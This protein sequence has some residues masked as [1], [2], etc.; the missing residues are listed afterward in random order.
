[1]K[2]ILG[3]G[4]SADGKRTMTKKITDLTNDD[5]VNVRQEFLDYLAQIDF[6]EASKEFELNENLDETLEEMGFTSESKFRCKEL[7]HQAVRNN[8][9]HLNERL[10]ELVG[11]YLPILEAEDLIEILTTKIDELKSAIAAVE[12]ESYL[13]A[14][15]Q[16]SKLSEQYQ[17]S[18][19][20][21]TAL[22]NNSSDYDELEQKLQ[23]T[24]RPERAPKKSWVEEDMEALNESDFFT[25]GGTEYIDPQMRAYMKALG[26]K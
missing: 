20:V 13:L 11:Q 10:A 23:Q 26:H 14:S 18:E 4:I 22:W 19:S 15:G 9:S 6:K 17:I 12:E 2:N 7:F 3:Q 21:V 1:M 25:N 16:V 24:S 5:P 8:T